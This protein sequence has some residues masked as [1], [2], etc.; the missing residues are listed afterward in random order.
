MG[1]Q[2]GH[3]DIELIRRTKD[4]IIGYK[5]VYNLTLL[6]NALLSLIVLPSESNKLRRIRFLNT[7]INDI[8][9]LKEIINSNEFYFDS[10]GRN[11]D[12]KNLLGRIRNGIAH[13]RIETITTKDKWTGVIIQD[14]DPRTQLIGLNLTL[15]TKQL[16]EFALFIASKYLDEVKIVSPNQQT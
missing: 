3:Y 7:N 10:R 1:I 4:L 14:V 11:Y 9:E 16:R 13:Q 15:T 12:L 2:E 6:M 5:G 8:D